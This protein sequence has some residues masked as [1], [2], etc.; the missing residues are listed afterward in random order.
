MRGR[1]HYVGAGIALGMAGGAMNQMAIMK[2]PF[3]SN[4]II[5]FIGPYASFMLQLNN[6]SP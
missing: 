2:M 6:M 4:G 3:Y 1:R 5:T